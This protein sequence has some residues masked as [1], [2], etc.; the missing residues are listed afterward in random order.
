MRYKTSKLTDGIL[1]NCYSMIKNTIINKIDCDL[2]AK[3]YIGDHQDDYAE[4]EFS[5]KYIDL[6]MKIYKTHKDEKA[7][8]NA[9]AVV[10]SVISNMREDGYIGGLAKGR[11]FTNFSVWNQMFTIFGLI[12]Y[13]KEV[14]DKRSLLAAEKCASY[15]MNYFIDNKKDI[16]DAPNYGTQ[17]ISILFVLCDLYEI[18]QK[19]KYKD[20][21]VHIVSR[22]KNSDL[23]FFEFD[24]ILK[25]RSRK[26]IEN[27]VILLSILKY[28]ELF[29]DSAA[30]AA[31]EKYWMQ[32]AETQI[33]NTGNGTIE[34]LWTENGNYA[35]MLGAEQRPNENCVA[36]GW[37]ELSLA[38]FHKKQDKKYL[39]A[40][41]K[42]LYNHIL[43][44]ISEDGNDFAYYQPNYGKKVRTTEDSMYKCCRYR[45]FTV[46]A[47]MDEMLYFENKSSI[48]PMLYT[49]SV[50]DSNNIKICIKTDYPFGSVVKV[51]AETD[52]DIKKQLKLR[53]PNG[54][55]LIK[56]SVNNTDTVCDITDGYFIVELEGVGH[57]EIEL[58]F[59]E[60]INTEYGFIDKKEYAAF[61]YGNVLLA[62]KD[63]NGTAA[64][65]KESLKFSKT[66][67]EENENIKFV[68]EGLI[69]GEK[70]LL[71]FTDYASADGYR[72]WVPVK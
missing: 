19:G 12:S 36:V 16:L 46:F 30:L 70:S 6:C 50:Y 10:E 32:V 47:Y 39:D 51:S 14:K 4:P 7:L 5:G 65:E 66:K 60:R 28:A 48:I 3:T 15:I 55:M 68:T 27:F 2:H 62:V 64:V 24:N 67:T 22:I 41:D 71:V 63:E 72:V 9:E 20:Y 38:L 13:Y 8:K 25:L 58:C 11:E 26:G 54:R 69:N 61:S 1:Y 31:V 57:T 33:R 59:D 43:A 49:N 40:V 29:D 17:H 37:V 52:S 18:T 56:A 45:G 44:S 42:T 53:I 23:N 35:A 34:E 21:I